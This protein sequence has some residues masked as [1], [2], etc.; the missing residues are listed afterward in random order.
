[1][2]R[3]ERPNRGGSDKLLRAEFSTRPSCPGG[4]NK[5]RGLANRTRSNAR[6]LVRAGLRFSAQL[7]FMITANDRRER[8][9]GGQRDGIR[10]HPAQRAMT[11]LKQWH[12]GRHRHIRHPTTTSNGTYTK[13]YLLLSPISPARLRRW[14]SKMVP[15]VDLG[16]TLED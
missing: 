13:H 5:T 6:F 9:R 16:M 4:N 3:S 12:I 1:M 11:K 7:L 2:R 10:R 14:H 15:G 8:E